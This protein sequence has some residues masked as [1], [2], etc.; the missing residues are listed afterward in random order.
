MS[1][2]ELLAREASRWLRFAAEDLDAAQRLPA[3]AAGRGKDV[4]CA[5][6]PSQFMLSILPSI[7]EPDPSHASKND[8]DQPH[9]AKINKRFTTTN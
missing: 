6:A 3:R 9:S 7:P 2:P 1:D 5:P 8:K 4:E